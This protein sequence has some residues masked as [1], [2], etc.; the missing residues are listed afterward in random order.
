MNEDE[1]YDAF[2]E[3]EMIEAAEIAMQN[4]TSP[5]R[6]GDFVVMHTCEDA[7]HYNGK[8]WKCE[9]DVYK[10]CNQ[11]VVQLEGFSGA[12]LI[13]YLQKVNINEVVP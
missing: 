11:H 12:F 10:L 1:M 7:K 9:T 2:V 8:V 4:A 13:E 5:F 3:Q 6:K